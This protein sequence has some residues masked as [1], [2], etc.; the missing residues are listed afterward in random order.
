MTWDLQTLPLTGAPRR[1]RDLTVY[2][3]DDEALIFDP[4]SS[5]THRLNATA[6]FIWKLCDGTR[7]PSCI[8]D[9]LTEHYEVGWESAREHSERILQ[10]F[11]AHGLVTVENDAS[12]E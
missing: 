11:A 7:E 12:A 10:E 3:L 1:R 8:A 9:A 2:E 5:D 6:V 4:K